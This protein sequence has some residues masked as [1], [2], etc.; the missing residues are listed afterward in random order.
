MKNVVGMGIMLSSV[1]VAWLMWGPLREF[2]FSLIPATAEY[3]WIGKLA[4]LVVIGY[5]GGIAVPL[6]LLM[7]GLIMLL[8]N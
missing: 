3:V 8:A 5:F 6:F 4:I 7:L 2:C 1:L